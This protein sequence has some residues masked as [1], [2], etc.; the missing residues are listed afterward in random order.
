MTREGIIR[1]AREAECEE[2]WGMDAF[3]FTV[4]ELER[5]TALVAAEERERCAKVC[6]R[7]R[8]KDID[9]NTALGWGATV[10]PPDYCAELI[11]RLQ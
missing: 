2:T 9:T 10:S 11:R 4:E 3:K 8:R 6:D 5:F 1:M 7:I